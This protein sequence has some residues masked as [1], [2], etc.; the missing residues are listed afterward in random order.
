MARIIRTEISDLHVDYNW[1]IDDCAKIIAMRHTYTT[2]QR[3]A[4]IMTV[5]ASDH[6]KVTEYASTLMQDL[7]EK[8]PTQPIKEEQKAKK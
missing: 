1:D 3:T 7:L 6:Q 4:N 2:K 8:L 5:K